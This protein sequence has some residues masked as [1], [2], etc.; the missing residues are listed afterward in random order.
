M[1]ETGDGLNG[2]DESAAGGAIAG[3]AVDTGAGMLI[4]GG[5]TEGAGSGIGANKSDD[6]SY[7]DS[8]GDGSRE[9]SCVA[10][11]CKVAGSLGSMSWF[12]NYGDCSTL[13]SSF[14][15]GGGSAGLIFG[16]AFLTTGFF[17]AFL[18][19]AFFTAL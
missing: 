5:A 17:T 11:F 3:T 2:E 7:Y 18:I 14:G 10:N 9:E 8:F 6:V 16:G 13:S 19:G 15:A 12:I 4:D 1:F